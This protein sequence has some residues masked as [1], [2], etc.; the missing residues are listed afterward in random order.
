MLS[1]ELIANDSLAK[2][3][4]YIYP[5]QGLGISMDVLSLRVFVA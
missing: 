1:T 4:I 3:D 5:V 2:D